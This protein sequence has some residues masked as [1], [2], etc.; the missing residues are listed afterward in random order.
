MPVKDDPILKRA[1][2]AFSKTGHYVISL[3]LLKNN[4]ILLKEQER[5]ADDDNTDVVDFFK[6]IFKH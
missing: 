2:T 1:Q 4:L 3:Q 5:K 6:K